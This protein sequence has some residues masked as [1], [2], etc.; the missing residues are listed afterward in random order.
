LAVIVVNDASP[1]MPRFPVNDTPAL[2][3]V[4][5]CGRSKSPAV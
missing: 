5:S 4:Q 3:I 2:V 1:V